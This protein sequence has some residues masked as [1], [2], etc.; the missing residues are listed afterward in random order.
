MENSYRF[1]E[2]KECKYYPCHKGLE[3]LNCLFCY[4]PLY[5]MQNCPGT[6]RMIEKEGKM[7]KTCIDCTFV[8]KPENYDK[9]NA[10]IKVNNTK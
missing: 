9:V 10:I 7:I 1:F 2:N 4:C 6:Y 3:E 5:H 8:H